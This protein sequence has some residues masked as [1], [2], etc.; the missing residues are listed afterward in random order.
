MKIT[1]FIENQ[2]LIINAEAREHFLSMFCSSPQTASVFVVNKYKLPTVDAVKLT[3][4]QIYGDNNQIV[5]VMRPSVFGNPYS[6]ADEDDNL[7]RLEKRKLVVAKHLLNLLCD[8]NTIRMIRKELHNKTL[9]CCCSPAMCHGWI[10]AYIANDYT[11]FCIVFNNFV[12]WLESHRRVGH[13]L[14]SDQIFN[15]ILLTKHSLGFRVV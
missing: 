6:V 14:V 13:S 4:P 3:H 5:S 11:Q 1:K 9:M 7:T 10:L 15:E 2:H 8:H 12:N